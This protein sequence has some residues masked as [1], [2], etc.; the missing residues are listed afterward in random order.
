[1]FCTRLGIITAGRPAAG[2]S[3]LS[4]TFPGSLVTAAAVV[5]AAAAAQ[6]PSDEQEFS[7]VLNQTVEQ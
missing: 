1:M 2:H 7:R 6:G 5:A 4:R 3:S